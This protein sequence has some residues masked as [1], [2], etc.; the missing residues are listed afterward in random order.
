M[1]SKAAHAE[2]FW[3]SLKQCFTGEILDE[4]FEQRIKAFCAFDLTMRAMK[5]RVNAFMTGMDHFAKALRMHSE[6]LCNGMYTDD[7]FL[8]SEGCKLKQAMNQISH[9]DAPHS[10]ISKIQ[11]DIDFNVVQPIQKH[12]T[13]NFAIVRML[14]QR[15]QKLVEMGLAKGLRHTPD[16]Q[17]QFET[18]VVAFHKLHAYIFEWFYVFEQHR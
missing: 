4:V 7:I 11:R 12:I 5:Q 9:N 6:G 8:A 14:E 1:T 17:K 2:A 15:R 10:H 16:G 13:N 18:A 3:N